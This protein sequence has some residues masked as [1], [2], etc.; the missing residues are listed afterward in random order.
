MRPE[1][2]KKEKLLINR[3][4]SAEQK[5]LMT[6]ET[7]PVWIYNVGFL[8]HR[9]FFRGMGQ[10]SI[11][12]AEN[13][14]PSCLCLDKRAIF[15]YDKGDRKQGF[16]IENPKEVAQDFLGISPFG[17]NHP[18]TNKTLQGLFMT[19]EPIEKLPAKERDALI[20]AAQQKFDDWTQ[21][22]VMEADSYWAIPQQRICISE[23]HRKCCLYLDA[24]GL[25]LA[26]EHA[27]LGRSNASAIGITECA[28]CGS[29]IK[30][31]VRKCPHCQEW[32]PGHEPQ[33]AEAKP[34]AT[35]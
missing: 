12:A 13:G 30:K 19:T 17:D 3:G 28:Y 20:T 5:D 10:I 31:T 29:P 18:T 23:V 26:K 8:A 6:Y 25:L 22:K 33:R 9:K 2:I 15:A 4:L 21:A 16:I 27:W 14:K 7:K 32:Q 1:Q 11:E 35:R 24:K 34:E